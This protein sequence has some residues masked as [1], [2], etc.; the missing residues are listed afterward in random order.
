VL[1]VRLLQDRYVRV[2]G[3]LVHDLA[4][5]EETKISS[6]DA[7]AAAEDAAYLQPIVEALDH[8]RD[9]FPRW[10]VVEA[11]SR[12]HALALTRE[13]AGVAVRRG[14]VAM[15]VD[16][17]IRFGA[18]LEAD[19]CDR[20]LFLA[21]TFGGSRIH[22]H[23]ALLS[24]SAASPRPHL[25]M[26]F[27]PASTQHNLSLVREARSAYADRTH[28]SPPPDAPEVSA[29]LTKA[30]R[31][32]D[33]SRA[34]R[35]VAA[36]RMLRDAAGALARRGAHRA[37]SR[38]TIELGRLLDQRARS[39]AASA[40]FD[41]AATLARSA[42]D[43]GLF[44]EARLWQAGTRIADGC[45]TEAE[46]LCRAAL[47]SRDLP[48]CLQ[49]WAQAT[50]AEAL[51]RQGCTGAISVLAVDDPLERLSGL[52]DAA[53]ANVLEIDVR[54]ALA[55][56]D[57]FDAGRRVEALGT[58]AAR[59]DDPHIN[60]SALC[61]DLAVLA[62]SG[63]L[64]RARTAFEAAMTASRAARAPVRAV[65]ARL[66]WVDA[67]VRGGRRDH[68]APHLACL[69]RIVRGAPL[70]LRREIEQRIAS[71]ERSVMRVS[72]PANRVRDASMPAALVRLAQEGEDETEA[73]TAVLGRVSIELQASRIDL[74]SDDAG[75]ASTICSVGDGLPT[76]LGIRVLE[77]AFAIGPERQRGGFEIGVPVRTGVRILGAIVARWPIDRAV[78]P[79][80]GE[81]LDLAAAVAAPRVEALRAA[82]RD[83]A[84][85][86]AT[87]PELLGVSDVMMTVRNAIVRAAAAP[88]AV[89]IEGESGVGKEL[90]AHALHQ[91]SPRRERRFCDVNCA[92]LPEELLESELF[93]HARGAFSG[94]ISDRAGLFEEAHGGT[95][96]LDEVADLSPRA[97]AKLLRAVQ[98]QE[99]RRV[100]ESFTRKVDVRLV[101]AANRDMRA[102]GSAGRFRQDLLYRLDVVHI[103]IPPLRERPADISPLALH[104]WRSAAARVGSRAEL[105]AA[106]LT[107]LSRYH[108]PGNVR[109]L[110]NVIAALAVAAPRSGFVRPALL[111][112]VIGAATTVSSARLADAREQFER[113]FVEVAL[114]RAGGNRA[115]AARSLGLSRQGL[116]KI[117]TRLGLT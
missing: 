63:D 59:S 96:F 10:L 30:C 71:P 89:L 53:A 113:R 4:T 34:G 102:E 90:A 42:G 56:G 73:I 44:V 110:Q 72:S 15:S 55:S 2:T 74:W 25:L 77:A 86:S 3:D 28:P 9:G 78:P 101:A 98:Q 22:A 61:A 31:A 11:R 105:S 49:T 60:A 88:F 94:A 16:A 87:V 54:L 85:A 62:H 46:S 76:V 13:L 100:G 109:E 69:K 107:E 39:D 40:A 5:G 45:L 95:L 117:L 80:A 83:E 17:F 21:G 64:V 106:V 24:A 103:Q 57:V 33:L 19:L 1:V 50:L 84:A 37:A 108:W 91:L 18:S 93:G 26:T 35:H 6:P 58:L 48:A 99:V 79:E 114:A 20:T 27:T 92:A 112:P 47:A 8:G 32:R 41:D 111:P 36:E 82:K 12:R 29:L 66:T 116:L 14:Y 52:D 7:A 23:A 115:R 75:P 51:L 43:G 68:A 70:L 65:W 67:L 104:C 81:L 97:Q 38:V